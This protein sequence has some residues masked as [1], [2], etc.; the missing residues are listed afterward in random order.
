MNIE[1]TYTKHQ[2]PRGSRADGE[3]ATRLVLIK[4]VSRLHLTY[5]IRLLTYFASQRNKVLVVRVPRHCEISPKL[6]EYF[7]QYPTLAKLERM[8]R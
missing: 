1:Y 5:Q 4:M 7:E 8:D 3:T 2:T 6:E